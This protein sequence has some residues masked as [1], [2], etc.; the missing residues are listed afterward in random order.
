MT[1]S[2]QDTWVSRGDFL[3]YQWM[4]GVVHVTSVINVLYFYKYQ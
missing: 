1:G 2:V 3:T 4:L